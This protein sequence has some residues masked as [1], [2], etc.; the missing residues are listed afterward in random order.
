MSTGLNCSDEIRHLIGTY[1]DCHLRRWDL[2][3]HLV[4]LEFE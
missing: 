2:A 4:R 1:P 3:R